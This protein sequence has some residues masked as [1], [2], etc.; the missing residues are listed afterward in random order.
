MKTPAAILVQTRKPLEIDEIEIPRL[1]EGQVLVQISHSGIC[2]TQ[3]NE[4]DG[5]KGEDKWLPHC[6]GH[7][8]VGSVVECGPS[9]SRLKNYD[10]VILSWL[11][12]E[13]IDAGGCQYGWRGKQVNAGPVTT[14][15]KYAVVSEN[16]VSK[17]PHIGLGELSL[18]LGCAA[19]TGMG[20]V[21]N[22]L[23]P[24]PGQSVLVLGAGGVGLC[25]VMMAK[26]LDLKPIIVADLS[27]SR[28]ELATKFGADITVNVS[29]QSLSE[30]ILTQVGG[31]VDHAVEVT[32]NIS[33]LNDVMNYLRPQGGRAVIISNAPAGQIMEISPSQFNMGKSLL[34]TWGGDSQPERD[35]EV[36]SKIMS[37][38]TD[39]LHKLVEAKF[40]LD[41]VNIALSEMRSRQIVRPILTMM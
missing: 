2:G 17:I 1:R 20:A 27:A 19:P 41:D 12:A 30:A 13:G 21:R 28:L 37:H 5:K 15:Q 26:Y 9:V 23:R 10:E 34:G 33:V 18:L 22:V 16:R 39:L 35:F 6:I 7:E 32:G 14:F 3:L 29:R 25:A 4:I 40:V 11:K 8:A 24:E 36:Y 31:Y 38:N